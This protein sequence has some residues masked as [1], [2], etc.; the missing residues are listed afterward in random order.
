[1]LVRATAIWFALLIAAIFNGAVREALIIPRAGAYVGHVVSTVSLSLLIL[2]IATASIDWLAP[3]GQAVSIGLY[4]LMLTLAFE[5]LAGH[6]LFGNPWSRLVDDYNV[7]QGRI[8]ILV[9]AVTV[10]APAIAVRVR[11]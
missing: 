3:G 10:F 8:W 1:M 2:A 9:L 11:A 6:Y 7:A 5:F 4:W